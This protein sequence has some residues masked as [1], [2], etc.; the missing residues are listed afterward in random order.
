MTRDPAGAWGKANVEA[1]GLLFVNADM[2]PL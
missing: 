1:A 2:V